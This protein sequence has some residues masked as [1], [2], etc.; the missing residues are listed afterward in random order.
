MDLI[1]ILTCYR[2]PY[3]LQ[4]QLKAVR[5]QTV[6]SDQIWLWVNH[7][8]DN[9]GMDFSDYGF[10]VILRSS[11]NFRCHGRF[12]AGL[13]AKSKYLAYYDDDTI[14]GVRWIENCRLTSQFLKENHG[15]TPTILGTAGVLLHSRRYMNSSR[16]G[17]PSK[18]RTIVEVDLVGHAWF[19]EQ[20]VM[21][22]LFYEDPEGFEIGDDIQFPYLAKKH[23]NVRTFVP[24]HPDEDRSLWGSLRAEE[25]GVD[26]K[27]LSVGVSISHQD[28]FEARDRAVSRGVDGGWKTILGVK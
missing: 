8:E 15:I 1:T 25:L 19:F 20:E 28:F 26:T 27:G 14:P 11:V 13:L 17:W 5:E 21:K 3:N 18:N 6:K 22:Y 9:Q 2:R 7:H 4:D 24:V 12:T 16:V 23:G 10:D